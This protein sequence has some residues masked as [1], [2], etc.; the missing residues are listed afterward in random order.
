M[1]L[2]DY[3][4]AKKF[5]H[6]RLHL[7]LACTNPL[8]GEVERERA[9]I[10]INPSFHTKTHT[11]QLIISNI[12]ADKN[13]HSH[14]LVIITKATILAL[15]ITLHS[16]GHINAVSHSSSSV[17]NHSRQGRWDL[18]L[19]NVGVV[20]MHMALTHHGT[21]IIFDQTQAGPSRYQLRRR[22]SSGRQCSRSGDDVSDPSC[23]AHSIEYDISTNRIRPLRLDTDPWCSSGSFLSNGTLLQAGGN[24]RGAR[25]IRYFRPCNNHHCDWRQSRTQLSDERWYA[26]SLALPQRDRVIV[27]GG[28]RVFSYEFVPK[29]SSNDNQAFHLPLLRSTN[30]R[31]SRGNNLYP[32]LHLSSDGNLFIF[33]NRDSILFN[34]RRNRVVKNFPRIPG[35]GSRNY[36]STGSSVILPLEHADRFQKVEVMVCGG[37]ASGA[38][39][40]SRRRHRYLEGLNSCGRMVISGN[41]HKWSME[42]MPGPRLMNDMLLLPTGDVLI[43]N[44]AER[45]VAGWDRARNASLRPFL[46]NA[47]KPQGGRFS[48]LRRT[49]I[50]RMYHSSAVLLPDGRVLVGGSNPNDRYTFS[51]VSYPTELRLQAFIPY[52]MD[53]Q[54]NSTRPANIT[55]HSQHRNGVVYG[56]EFHVRFFMATKPSRDVDFVVY[57]PP[58][59]THSMSMNQRL[60]RLRAKSMERDKTG[61]VNAV[62]EAPPSA[63][64]APSGYY[65]LTIVNQGIPSLSQWVRF[66]HS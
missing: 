46:Y 7:L 25:R 36:P 19:D 4:E 42:R 17:A 62:L 13:T 15:L 37:S 54:Y 35:N 47:T 56:G 20:A 21:V 53:H 1:H 49:S 27:V 12:M 38:Y 3:I 26:S 18:L 39:R 58:F 29:M 34:Y 41:T 30:D 57:A 63:N 55:I 44:G 43:I 8:V 40:A 64:V 5:G 11:L 33:A 32:F 45:G 51:G 65:M 66:I 60:L 50:P 22:F 48:L 16:F 52:Y 24:G 2:S 61:W 6:T 59:T 14:H 31:N 28:R 9:Y 23:F 10:Y